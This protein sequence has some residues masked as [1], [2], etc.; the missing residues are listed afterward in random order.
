M[1]TPGGDNQDVGRKL[2]DTA[3][4]ARKGYQDACEKSGSAIADLSPGLPRA[5]ESL[6]L[7]ASQALA[8]YRQALDRYLDFLVRGAIPDD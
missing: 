2:R 7:Q 3:L 1:D 5:N 8:R 4:K 6:P